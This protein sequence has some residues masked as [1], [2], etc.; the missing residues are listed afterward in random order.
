MREI[1][2]AEKKYINLEEAS[3]VVLFELPAHDWS[4]LS[5]SPQW[6]AVENFLSQLNEGGEKKMPKIENFESL[7]IDINKG[8]YEVNGHDISK[9]GKYLKLIFEDG[10]WSLMI[11]GDLFYTTSDHG[12]KE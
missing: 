10:E 6:G 3:V 4:E 2:I 8:I 9:S 5:Q 12:I 11:S 7:H 1:F